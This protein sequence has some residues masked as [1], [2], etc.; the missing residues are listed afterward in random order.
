MKQ[1]TLS[2][3]LVLMLTL[4]SWA[5]G[6]DFNKPKKPFNKENAEA[7]KIAFITQHLQLSELQAT[8]FWPIF[9]NYEAEKK[10]LRENM[11]G[12]INS[13]KNID[14]LSDAEANQMLTNYISFKNKE[15]ELTEKYIPEFKKVLD[16]KQVVKLITSKKQFGKMMNQYKENHGPYN[17]PNKPFPPK[18]PNMPPQD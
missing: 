15:N 4:S 16:A 8:K 12:G 18:N 10:S 3:A 6:T 13:K 17:K 1:I 5:E 7:M 2:F 9:N 11:F 14:S